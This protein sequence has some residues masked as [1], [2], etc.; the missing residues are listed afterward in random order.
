MGFA[1]F[2]VNLL[3]PPEHGSILFGVTGWLLLVFAFFFFTVLF[4]YIVNLRNAKIAN[5]VIEVSAALH[6]ME[7]FENITI[8]KCTIQ[9][10]HDIAFGYFPAEFCG[11]CLPKWLVGPNLDIARA[12]RDRRHVGRCHRVITARNSSPNVGPEV[13]RP[14][15]SSILEV[16]GYCRVGPKFLRLLPQNFK[17]Y[18]LD[19]HVRP[20]NLP[21]EFSGEQGSI[22]AIS[23]RY[24]GLVSNTRLVN[25]YPQTPAHV[26]S[27]SAIDP[28]LN[29][30]GD[31]DHHRR[32]N[33]PPIGRR[34]VGLVVSVVATF[35]FAE[36]RRRSR[37]YRFLG[38]ISY[39][40]FC[41]FMTLLVL[42]G[43]TWT[44]GWWL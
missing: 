41:V 6:R 21:R 35:C 44:W 24:C 13:Y 10:I 32:Y 26:V 40:A 8:G 33:Q 43:F 39:F 7:G 5:H 14:S 18:T 42:S 4:L 31:R 34:L 3:G 36:C 11:Q 15:L 38:T 22:S 9:G 1:A 23:S 30:S 37:L 16:Y 20:Q 27:L 12:Y 28:R 17:L 2:G 19:V 29:T 25:R